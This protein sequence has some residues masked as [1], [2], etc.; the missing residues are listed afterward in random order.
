M[1][2]CKNKEEEELSGLQQ[3]LVITPYLYSTRQL[4]RTAQLP[5]QGIQTCSLTAGNE[6]NVAFPEVHTRRVSVFEM[7]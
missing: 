5:T 3:Y 4:S 6:L 2:F 1:K 7:V